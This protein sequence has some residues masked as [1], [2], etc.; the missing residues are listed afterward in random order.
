M[1]NDNNILNSHLTF[2]K[3]KIGFMIKNYFTIALRSLQR[4]KSYAVINIVGLAVGIAACLLLFLVISFENSFDNFHTKK[5]SY[6]PGFFRIQGAGEKQLF[7]RS[8]LSYR[9][10]ITG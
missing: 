1:L 9:A 5:K 7:C 3:F 10:G 8:S 4:N 2:K 6:L